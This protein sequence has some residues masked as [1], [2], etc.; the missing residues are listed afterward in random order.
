[1]SKPKYWEIIAEID[2]SYFTLEQM[3][4]QAQTRIPIERMIDESTGYDK[5][6]ID[7]AKAIVGRI[8]ELQAL[9]PDDDPHFVNVPHKEN[10][11]E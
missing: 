1:M 8:K 7:E 10:I 3:A 6:R 9:L 4:K 11:N 2:A 5:H